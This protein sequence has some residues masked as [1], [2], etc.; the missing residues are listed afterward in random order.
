M[1]RFLTDNDYNRR[2]QTYDLQQ[3]LMDSADPN[4]TW[5]QPVNMDILYML[6][7][8]AQAEITSY[9]IKRYDISQ[10][11][12]PT[13]VFNLSTVYNANSLVQVTAPVFS[14]ANTYTV[15]ARISYSAAP[16]NNFIYYCIQNGYTGSTPNIDTAYWSGGTVENGQLFYVNQPAQSYD[17]TGSYMIGDQVFYKNYIYQALQASNA[18]YLMENSGTEVEND[19]TSAVIPTISK[20]WQA[21]WSASTTPYTVTGI[22]PDL[23]TTGV[24]VQGDNRNQLMVQFMLDITLYHASARL[25]PRNTVELWA[26]RYDGNNPTQNG[27]AIAML[28][29]INAGQM[30]LQEPELIP[31][32]GQSIFWTSD[33]KRSLD[34]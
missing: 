19:F 23:D 33:S 6:E 15:G 14:T 34:Y 8:Q 28:K 22:Y 11:F 21:T 4:N 10:V 24:W 31:Q 9:L 27:G 5:Q 32:Q 25:N 1:N 16:Y 17:V 2:I 13:T 20:N 29:K 7:Q 12:R 3:L 26:I 18:N 30:N